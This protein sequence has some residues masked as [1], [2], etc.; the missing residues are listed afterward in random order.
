MGLSTDYAAL[1]LL[2]LTVK[3]RDK[4]RQ[5]FEHYEYKG[6]YV[7]GIVKT[8]VY[9]CA[10][11]DG[12]YLNSCRLLGHFPSSVLKYNHCVVTVVLEA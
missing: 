11:E 12:L 3:S 10:V 1:R 4:N 6:H 8:V 5:H 2:D 7:L 9:M